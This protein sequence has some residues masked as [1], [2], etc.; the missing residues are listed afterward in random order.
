M[1]GDNKTLGRFILDGIL[2]APRGMPQIEVAFDI[3]ANG[4]LKVTAADKASGRMQHITIGDRPVPQEK[5]VEAYRQ[6][7]ARSVI[8]F[9]R[10]VF[11]RLQLK[12]VRTA[13]GRNAGCRRE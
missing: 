6:L 5:I 12:P 2:P 13:L 9:D 1:A 11:E 8:E 7:V 4:I 10:G 3:D